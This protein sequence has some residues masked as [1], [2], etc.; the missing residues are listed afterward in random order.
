MR[1][2]YYKGPGLLLILM[3]SFSLPPSDARDPDSNSSWHR[4]TCINLTRHP[5]AVCIG[6]GEHY[7]R[8]LLSDIFTPQTVDCEAYLNDD[9]S[10]WKVYGISDIPWYVPPDMVRKTW[11]DCLPDEQPARHRQ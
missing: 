9:G 1:F 2:C 4:G 5:I 6:R 8:L 10:A 11:P 7:Q 3:L